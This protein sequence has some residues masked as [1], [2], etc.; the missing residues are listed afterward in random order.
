MLVL[1]LALATAQ[2]VPPYQQIQ[3]YPKFDK[4][5]CAPVDANYCDEY[6]ID[7][8]ATLVPKQKYPL[9]IMFHGYGERADEA[10]SGPS[11]SW[12]PGARAFMDAAIGWT[13][14][15][16]EYIV[17]FHDGGFSSYGNPPVDI[18]TTYGTEEFMRATEAVLEDVVSKWP[19]D[20]KRM[21]GYGLSMG[22]GECLAFAA[23]HQD[24]TSK[25]MLSAVVNQSGTISLT[26]ITQTAGA[27]G[28]AN[29][30]SLFSTGLYGT[31]AHDNFKYQRATAM[32]LPFDGT[33]SA[34]LDY[35]QE[36]DFHQAHNLRWLPRMNFHVTAPPDLLQH[37]VEP[38]DAL[39]SFLTDAANV[40]AAD[41]VPFPTP[42]AIVHSWNAI[43]P[44]D[45]LTYFDARD[46]TSTLALFSTDLP[47]S[48]N[49]PELMLFA[50]DDTR[51]HNLSVVR[52]DPGLFGR[53]HVKLWKPYFPTINA[54]VFSYGFDNATDNIAA[55]TIHV[56]QHLQHLDWSNTVGNRVTVA[57]NLVDLGTIRAVGVAAPI[58]VDELVSGSW[59]LTTQGVDWSHS[60]TTLELYE[61]G[62]TGLQR[63]WR[64]NY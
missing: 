10:L 22:G 24:P 64:V 2:A 52:T 6:Y 19:V 12:L 59:T 11:G 60:G 43:A 18:F 29:W 31:S 26:R 1:A 54:I 35:L 61:D 33:V 28:Q 20:R 47:T 4:L 36:F 53:L 34:P 42:A 39:E 14:G 38:I 25:T 58:T 37:M 32:D 27:G 63:Q 56:D 21:Y 55:V 13:G 50:E 17:V 57:A 30:A 15:P 51:H 16:K 40:N 9:I 8:P 48:S 7:G 5:Y 46:K 3:R 62:A 45:I 49:V 44:A 41:Q 23:R